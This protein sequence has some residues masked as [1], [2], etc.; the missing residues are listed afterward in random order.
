MRQRHWIV[1]NESSTE[2][3]SIKEQEREKEGGA[4]LNLHVPS[5]S[6]KNHVDIDVERERMKKSKDAQGKLASVPLEVGTNC[7]R[8]KRR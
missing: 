6:G 1:R 2:K 3:T 4:R 7:L 5:M 8:M